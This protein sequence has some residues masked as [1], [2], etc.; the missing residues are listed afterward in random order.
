MPTPDVDAGRILDTLAR[1]GVEFVL[2]GGFAVELHDV[3]VPPTRDID[4]TPA[5]GAA[6]LE[7]L[8]AAL[9]ELGARLRVPGGPPEGVAV[10]SGIDTAFLAGRAN[11]ALVTTAGPLDISMRPDGTDGYADLA[12]ERVEL[13]YEGRTVPVASLADIVRSKEAAGRPKD[14][15]ELPALLEHLRRFGSAAS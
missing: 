3:A 2:I 6:N 8:T 5:V 15:M 4:I 11:V 12:A 14:V 13:E 10:P 7:R 1:H 9:Q